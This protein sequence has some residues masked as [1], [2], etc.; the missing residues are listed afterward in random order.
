MTASSFWV[1]INVLI[2]ALSVLL[3]LSL[4]SLLFRE[5]KLIFMVSFS[6]HTHSTTCTTTC[7]NIHQS[8]FVYV[9]IFCFFLWVYFSVAM[10][11]KKIFDVILPYNQHAPVGDNVGQVNSPLL[12][13]RLDNHT[14][15][16]YKLKHQ[17]FV[18]RFIDVKASYL[19]LTITSPKP[20]L[21][22]PTYSPTFI[23]Y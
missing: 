3:S 5:N 18:E 13:S 17:P 6:F 11:S 19:L 16:Y 10:N 20:L 1:T 21:W 7:A 23:S 2:S 15:E 12:C 4:T 9:I 22:V 8:F 14:T